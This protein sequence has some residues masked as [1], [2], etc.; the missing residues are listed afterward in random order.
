MSKTAQWPYFIGKRPTLWE[1]YL[2]TRKAKRNEL[3][4]YMSPL[5]QRESNQ[6][7]CQVFKA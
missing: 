6:A 1:F 2:V 4:L 5:D 3:T 7:P